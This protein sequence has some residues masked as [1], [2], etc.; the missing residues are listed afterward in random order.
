MNKRLILIT[1]IF[2]TILALI[3]CV[4]KIEKVTTI[5]SGRVIEESQS[6]P[7]NNVNV[8][9]T[10][11]NQEYTNTHT[12]V[13]G[14]F[15][16]DVTFDDLNDNYYLYLD[17]GNHNKRLDLKGVGKSSYDY[18]DIA[19]YKDSGGGGGGSATTPTVTTTTPTN[20]TSNT[21]TC[22]GNVTE[23]GGAIVT[24]R[25]VC[26]NT[27]GNPTISN[28]HTTDG[29]GTG[30]FTSTITGLSANTTY[31]VKAY[32]TNSAGT[33][34]GTQK[35]FTTSGG[36]G[37]AVEEFSEGFE[38]GMPS[39]WTILDAND[40]SWTWTLTSDIP[41]TW[42]YYATTLL[43][44]YRTGSNAICSGSY[45]NGVGSLTPNEYL[46][47]P[48]A[49]IK[50]SSIFSFWAAACD[51]EYPEDHF[52]VA[53][54]T[55]TPTASAFTMLQEWTLTAKDGGYGGM[56]S[57]NGNGAKTG[58]WYQYSVNLS[59]YAG[60]NVY[61]AIRHFNCNDQYIMC[62]DD[63]QLSKNGGG[64]GGQT[65]S[66]TFESGLQNWT[67]LDADGDGY[68]WVLG[69]QIGGVYLES[70]TSLA[71]NG[72]GSSTDLVCSGSYTN[73]TSS[74]LYPD[75]YL[76]SPQKYTITAGARISFYVCAQ[77]S[78]YPAEHFGVAISTSSNPSSSSFTTIWEETLSAKTG[79]SE[80]IR[81]NRDQGTWY[82]KT[83][84][85]SSYSGQTIWIAIR[86]FDC[87]DQFI[88]DIDDI[89][90]ITGN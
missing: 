36:G 10:N 58:T 39:G 54:S 26:W 73:Y 60:Q 74:A 67:S 20:V 8:V 66:Y 89:T 46:I 75:N 43:D 25:G 37:S 49:S 11:G 77:D 7:L 56:A 78:E 83:I 57:R 61:I 84:D 81:G 42:T 45:I 62:V 23:D 2:L 38:S 30:Q 41:S 32:A 22:G 68:G 18:K 65:Y 6:M 5:L 14:T 12:G 27:S 1:S 21:A 70:G 34:Y 85:L 16:L 72:H 64:G 31:Y 40:D 82:L 29:T 76:V 53:I 59:A 35:T 55:T 50:N 51:T 69:S 19:L 88:L 24:A 80:I 52:G 47:T 48:L 9:V 33:S 86:H 28:Q 90:I 87:S 13:T 44:W 4:K 71:G 17:D 15:K 63:V 79:K 3:G